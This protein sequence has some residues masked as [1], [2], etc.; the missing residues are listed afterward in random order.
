MTAKNDHTGDLI[1]SKRNT[2]QYSDN[3][4]RIFGDKKPAQ[5]GRFVFDSETKEFVPA[6]E[7]YAAKASK[8]EKN[9]SKLNMPAVHFFQEYQS[10]ASGRIIDSPEKE[11]DELKRTGCRIF[12][13]SEQE[14][15]QAKAIKAEKKEKQRQQTRDLLRKTKI[16]L[17]DGMTPKPN[18]KTQ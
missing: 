4:S 16:Q 12:E 14:I 18:F 5:R 1:M 9:R 7:Y 10:P 8:E 17:R 3:Y 6:A 13:G 2:R 15:K 11:R